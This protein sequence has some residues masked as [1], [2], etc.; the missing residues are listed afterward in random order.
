MA[1]VATVAK[2]MASVMMSET[3]VDPRIEPVA[4][5][6]GITATMTMAVT[7][8]AMKVSALMHVGDHLGRRNGVLQASRKSRCRTAQGQGYSGQRCD[9]PKASDGQGPVLR[10]PLC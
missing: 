8:P 1:T 10:S 4:I 9:E 3:R 2:E 5:F 7:P 6:I